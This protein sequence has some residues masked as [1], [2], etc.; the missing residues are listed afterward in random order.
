MA[1]DS[2]ARQHAWSLLSQLGPEQLEAVV[3]LLEVMTD[4]IARS[5]ASAPVE[6]EPISAEEAAA[7]D[8]A[9]ASIQRGEGIPHEEV[10]REFGLR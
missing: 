10:L 5:L 3:R 7:L 2:E 6:D 4:P 9:H 8:A 1:S